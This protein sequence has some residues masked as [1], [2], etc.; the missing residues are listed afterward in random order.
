M[1]KE[2]KVSS[3]AVKK[4]GRKKGAAA[5][6]A[7]GDGGADGGGA[8][9]GASGVEPTGIGAVD[10]DADADADGEERPQGLN[11]LLRAEEEYYSS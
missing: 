11:E 8:D 2:P 4:G 1:R 5:V 6:D 7:G 10:G 3:V 9:G